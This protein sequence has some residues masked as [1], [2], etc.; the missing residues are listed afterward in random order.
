MGNCNPDQNKGKCIACKAPW[1][2]DCPE[3]HDNMYYCEKAGSA[4][5]EVCG[6]GFAESGSKLLPT[7]ADGGIAL[8]KAAL[9][10]F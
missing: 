9:G 1:G 6:A 7:P 3:V 4:P 2:T 5:K 8:A 10:V